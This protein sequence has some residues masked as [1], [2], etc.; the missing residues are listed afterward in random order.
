MRRFS[1]RLVFSLLISGCAAATLAACAPSPIPTGYTYHRQTYKS[2]PA[3][4]AAG[5]GYAFSLPANEN[6]TQAWRE[7][8]Q[9]L[10][11]RLENGGALQGRAVA[12]IPPRKVDQFNNSLYYAL[13]E[14][15]TA[16]G[17]RLES[18]SPETPGI[19][20]T[21]LPLEEAVRKAHQETLETYAHTHGFA[22]SDVTGASIRLQVYEGN[23][24]TFE[25]TDTYT[26][27]TFGHGDEL[28]KAQQPLFTPSAGQSARWVAPDLRP[29]PVRPPKTAEPSA[30][31]TISP[32][33]EDKTVGDRAVNPD[34][35]AEPPITKSDLEPPVQLLV[36]AAASSTP[37]TKPEADENKAPGAKSAYSQ[38]LNN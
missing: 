25:T 15:F 22:P 16:R 35:S 9:D 13:D 32:L 34:L 3:P 14:A 1:S 20:F 38:R 33:G 5:I 6:A 19:A 10:A 28:N 29:A 21:I 17:G 37:D 31:V 8:G 24:V 7:I 12:V 11:G 23:K 36:P 18:Y 2:P 26:I 27:P 30:P 4:K